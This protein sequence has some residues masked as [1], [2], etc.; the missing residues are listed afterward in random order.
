[1]G[2]WPA[3]ASAPAAATRLADSPRWPGR[4]T[5][6]PVRSA[7]WLLLPPTRR[8]FRGDAAAGPNPLW[9]RA[10]RRDAAQHPASVLYRPLQPALRLGFGEGAGPAEQFLRLFLVDREG[11][12]EQALRVRLQ[13]GIAGIHRDLLQAVTDVLAPLIG[14]AKPLELRRPV[15]HR[16][17]RL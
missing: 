2:S 15:G 1:P 12:V 13:G 10:T 14:L 9:H 11:Q 4:R 16:D 6:Q 7:S 5:A 3:A 17:G 8:L